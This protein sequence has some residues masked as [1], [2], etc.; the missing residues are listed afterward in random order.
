M[1]LRVKS[2]D[3]EGQCSD[4]TNT[5]VGI[6]GETAPVVRISMFIECTVLPPGEWWF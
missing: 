1:I 5:L 3:S 2:K 4:I 6:S